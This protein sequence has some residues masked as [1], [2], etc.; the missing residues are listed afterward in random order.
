MERE[1]GRGPLFPLLWL[2]KQLITPPFLFWAQI[3]PLSSK[4]A[5]PKSPSDTCTRCLTAF[6]A[7]TF[8]TFKT[9]HLIVLWHL[10]SLLFPISINTTTKLHMLK[11]K[12]WKSFLI[13][14]CPSLHTVPSPQSNP[15]PHPCKQYPGAASFHTHRT[16]PSASCVISGR[17]YCNNPDRS[18]PFF[19][20]PLQFIFSH[21]S[22][23]EFFKIKIRA[24]LVAQWWRI[25]LPMHQIQVQS[26]IQGDSTCYR[27]TKLMYH[28]YWGC[29]LE[30][31]SCSYWSRHAF[32]ST[33]NNNKSHRDEK[34]ANGN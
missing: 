17:N 32:E 2:L 12:T 26:L 6:S 19:T 11:L 23:T 25:H 9:E 18:P 22:K 24:S 34:S 31:G 7:L 3:S 28:K 30:P 4:S 33:L 21:Y 14:P 10:F 13:L 20:R 15:S 27:A 16:H 1:L 29:S 5:H 8:S